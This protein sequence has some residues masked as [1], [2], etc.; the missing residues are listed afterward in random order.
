MVEALS[1]GAVLQLMAAS[2]HYSTKDVAEMAGIGKTTLLRWLRE[3]RVQEPDRD[4]RGWRAWTEAEAQAVAKF[5]TRIVPHPR[6][7]QGKL[8]L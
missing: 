8:D 2:K 5:A 1:G 6:K 4:W 3:G 7:D